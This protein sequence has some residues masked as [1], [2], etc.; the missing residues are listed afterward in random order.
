MKFE[1]ESILRDEKDNQKQKRL[2]QELR[3]TQ[4]I[5]QQSQQIQMPPYGWYPPEE[6]G[7]DL[8]DL[9]AVLFQRKWF[10]AGITLMFG[11]LALGATLMI[12]PKYMALTMLEIGQVLNDRGYEN[13]ES[14]DAIVNRS[15]SRA[16]AIVGEMRK[17]EEKSVHEIL[18]SE[19]DFSIE[20]DF[21]VDVPEEGNFFS[22]EITAPKK[23]QA[24]LLLSRIDQALVNDHNRIFNHKRNELENKIVQANLEIKDI[25][26]HIVNLSNIIDD[27]KRQYEQKNGEMKNSIDR[28]DSSIQNIQSQQ[29]FLKE[30]ITLLQQEKE[31]LKGR[32]TESETRYNE[33]INYKLTANTEARGEEAIGLMLF[34]S[35][36]Q[37]MQNY[38]SQLRELLMFKIPANISEFRTRL[39]ELD[40]DIRNIQAEKN[41]AE[42]RL[43]QLEPE[44]KEKIEKI[45][46]QIKATDGAKQEKGLGIKTLQNKLDYMITTRVIVPPEFSEDPVSPNMKL[47]VALGLVWGVFISVFLGFFLAF[48]GRNKE[49]IVSGGKISE[50]A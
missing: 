16:K 3:E 22:M 17:A 21:K 6:D 31:D 37:N 20:D 11:C 41:L 43:Q 1:G 19:L 10:L 14:A 15:L 24:I 2:K 18:N 38:L 34:S 42:K 29:D 8:A 7:I 5:E 48:W 46:G 30:K 32:I 28:Q 12:T 23:S 35:E 44:Q 13:V 33:L 50:Q 27:I 39:K 4:Q 9:L 49:K 45:Q 36:A 26:I 40:N 47:N 25:D